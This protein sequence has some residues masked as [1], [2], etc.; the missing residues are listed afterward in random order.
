MIFFKDHQLQEIF[1]GAVITITKFFHLMCHVADISYV[2][3]P[4]GPTALAFIAL[5]ISR[6]AISNWFFILTDC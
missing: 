4:T 6:A 2:N 5:L 1:P 3:I